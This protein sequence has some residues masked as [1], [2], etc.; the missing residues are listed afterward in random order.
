MNRKADCNISCSLGCADPNPTFHLQCRICWMF[1]FSNF[2]LSS[3]RERVKKAQKLK[4]KKFFPQP[5][6][7]EVDVHIQ[8]IVGCIQYS[9]YLEWLSCKLV[10]FCA[11]KRWPIR[12][13]ALCEPQLLRSRRYPTSF[14]IVNAFSLAKYG[15]NVGTLVMFSF[16]SREAVWWAGNYVS[17][18]SFPAGFRWNCCS[19]KN[20]F[21]SL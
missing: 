15:R 12:W 13:I 4:M 11:F 21:S 3:E 17:Q 16:R 10:R 20:N 5:G 9:R 6:M 18:A 8:Q 2:Q 7:D 14:Q 19:S 1:L